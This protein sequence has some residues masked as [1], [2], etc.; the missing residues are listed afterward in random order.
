MF[1][2]KLNHVFLQSINKTEPF[3]E[4]AKKDKLRYETEVSLK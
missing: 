1:T 3:Y 2:I 4:K